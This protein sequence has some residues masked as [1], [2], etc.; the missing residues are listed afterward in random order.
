MLP[1]ATKRIYANVCNG[2][3]A[4]DCTRPGSI[5]TTWVATCGTLSAT[6]GPFVD[7]TAP[8][9]GGPCTITA[10]SN[11]VNAVATVTL[12]SPTAGIDVIPASLTLYK[13][14]LALVQ[15]VATGSINRNVTWAFTSN[16]GSAG[17]L[18]SQGWTVTFSASAAGTYTFTATSSAD[19]TKSATVTMYVT[20]NAMPA[21]ATVNHTEPVDC[22]AVGSGMTY[23]VGPTRAFTNPSLVP[24]Y[25]L[26]AGDTVRIHNDGTPGV[27]TVYAAKWNMRNSG[28]ASQPIRVCGVPSANGELP[29]ITGN[30]AATP[31]TADYGVI[32]NR[33]LVVIYD[34]RIGLANF[35]SGTY[36]KYITIEGIAFQHATPSFNFNLVAGGSQAWAISSG[37]LWW[38]SGAHLT[39]RGNDIQDTS[40]SVFANSQVTLG[41]NTMTRYW[42]IEGNYFLNN[43]VVGDSKEHQVYAQAF[44]QVIQGNYYDEPK[45]GMLGSQ[46]KLR[47][48]ECFT[49]YNFISGMTAGTRIFDVVAPEG[50]ANDVL[51]QHWYFDSETSIG[52][53]DVAAVEDW[54]GTDYIYG[55][56]IKWSQAQSLIHYSDDNCSDSSHGGILY[57]YHNTIWENVNVNFRWYMLDTGPGGAPCQASRPPTRYAAARFT[58][59]VI[60]LSATTITNPFFFWSHYYSGFAAVDSNWISISWGTGVGQGTF[61][62]GTAEQTYTS[63]YQTGNDAHHV[64]G[65][66]NLI[67]GTGTPFNASTYFPTDAALIGSAVALP[68]SAAQLPVTMQYNPSTFLMSPRTSSTDI[69]AV[70]SGIGPAPPTGVQVISVGTTLSPGAS[71]Q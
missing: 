4:L 56:I 53:N 58:N 35:G 63:E 9:S 23:E 40:N 22:T 29:V 68:A 51:E 28:T 2:T 39:Y 25:S 62:N 60:K 10:T 49:R 64:T 67:T 8:A 59:N 14:Q 32:E 65:M 26:V 47:C 41:E 12:A 36:P 61:G 44:G 20:A 16:P 42:L 46:I 19:G 48:T 45:N 57:V 70:S 37:A 21:T 54:Y 55:N 11:A 69:G 3:N 13:N 1:N 71:I 30:N 31:A 7:Y 33:G 24:W 17:T 43:G 50:S 27:P 52:I 38:Q 66:S 34:H 15:A 5:A 18:T 6:S